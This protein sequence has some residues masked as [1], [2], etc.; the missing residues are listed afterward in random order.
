MNNQFDKL[1]K[2][3]AQTV[4]RRQALRRCGLGLGGA[5]LGIA[6]LARHIFAA[7]PASGPTAVITQNF[8][9][10]TINDCPAGAFCAG[11]D[12]NG[13]VGPRHFVELINNHYG[14]YRKSDGVWVQSSSMDDFWVSAGVAFAQNEHTVDPH[15]LYDPVAKRWYACA[16]NN[17]Y[18][19]G[20]NSYIGTDLL[21]AVSKSSD[22]ARGWSGFRISLHPADVA[23]ADGTMMGFNRDG[24]FLRTA[25][26]SANKTPAAYLGHTVVVLPKSDLLSA[27]PSVAGRTVFDISGFDQ[28]GTWPTLAVDPNTTGAA[29][30]LFSANGGLSSYPFGVYKRTDIVGPVT[31]PTLD[32]GAGYPDKFLF[33]RSYRIA[34]P[35]PQPDAN[36][37]PLKVDF[38]IHQTA[39]AVKDGELWSVTNAADDG[40]GRGSIH[41]LRVS[42]LNNTLIEED[43][44]GHPELTYF[45]PS[46]A[47]NGKGDVVIGFNACGPS[48]GQYASCYAVVGRTTGAGTVFGQP[49]LLKAGA[50]SYQGSLKVDSFGGFGTA[51]YWGDYSA[52]SLDPEDPNTFW[53]IQQWPSDNNTWSTQIT[54][55]AIVH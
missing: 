9:G 6:G 22:P 28:I 31:S 29:G 45:Y 37:L 23:N 12:A 8:T 11:P 52:T 44:I 26:T 35:G 24:V 55:L 1:A 4:T 7:D 5:L 48:P 16:L 38:P 20:V 46:I 47:V 53:T 10:S 27:T 13:A 17:N 30:I 2:G 32:F 36:R 15:L 54:A 18:N 41:W 49:I 42:L 39:A 51:A 21:F 19:K 33:G 43:F 25:K 14:A 50:V 34:P 40:S 3:L